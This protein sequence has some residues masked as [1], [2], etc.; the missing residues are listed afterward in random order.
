MN[1]KSKVLLSAVTLALTLSPLTVF[2]ASNGSSVSTS[3]GI[4]VKVLYGKGKV[5]VT[6]VGQLK[7]FLKKNHIS[8]DSSTGAKSGTGGSKLNKLSNGKSTSVVNKAIL[9]PKVK[10]LLT[11]DKSLQKELIKKGT[12]LSTDLKKLTVELKNP[13]VRKADAAK[14]KEIKYLVSKIGYKKQTVKVTGYKMTE[15][16]AVS[17]LTSSIALNTAYSTGLTKA[18]NDLHSLLG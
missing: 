6:T 16:K 1:V 18:I 8:Y 14:L 2:A 5:G 15:A 4:Q 12:I 17:M 13:T 10:A 11:K 3:K 7:Q 9:S